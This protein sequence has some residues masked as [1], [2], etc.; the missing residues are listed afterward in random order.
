MKHKMKYKIGQSVYAYVKELDL[1]VYYPITD[2]HS[3]KTYTIGSKEWG[4]IYENIP[5]YYITK[6]I[7][8]MCKKVMGKEYIYKKVLA[9]YLDK[10]L[11]R[12]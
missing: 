10:H 9:E 6:T 12:N 4:I 8:Q 2:I 3:D 11:R 7:K 5:E 1:I